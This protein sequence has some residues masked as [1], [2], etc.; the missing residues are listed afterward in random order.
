ML[1]ISA[2][3]RALSRIGFDAPNPLIRNAGYG[4]IVV[5][6]YVR[7]RA[8]RDL[9]L[10][11]MGGGFLL[12]LEPDLMPLARSIVVV[13]EPPNDL[14]AIRMCDLLPDRHDRLP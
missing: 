2:D 7:A 13:R 14:L 11:V 8:D 1:G 9:H 10:I 6:R 3:C 4:E 12:G 5:E